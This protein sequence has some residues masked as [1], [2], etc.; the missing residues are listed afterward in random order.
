MSFYFPLKTRTHPFKELTQRYSLPQPNLGNW[1]SRKKNE[2]FKSVKVMK[3]KERRR[4]H[5]T[6]GHK[7]QCE[8]LH[9]I[10]D[11]KKQ[12]PGKTR[13]MQIKSGV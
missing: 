5:Q 2:L 11:R 1:S 3:E 6:G 10:L 7:M 12:V 13:E 4:N 9:G 8:I